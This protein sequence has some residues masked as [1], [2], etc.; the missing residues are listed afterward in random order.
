MIVVKIAIFAVTAYLALALLLYVYQR[1]IQYRPDTARVPPSAIGLTDVAEIELESSGGVRVIAWYAAPEA[2]KPVILFMHGNG[3]SISR[4]GERLA[5]YRRRGFGVMFLSY[6]GYGGSTGSPTEAGL[7]DD[8][9]AAYDWLGSQGYESRSIVLVG[10][11][12]GS[13]VAVQLA[14]RRKVAAVALE[15]PF[16]SVTDVA[17]R[18]YWYLPVGQLLKDKFDSRSL[19]AKIGAPLLIAHGDRDRVVDFEFGKRLFEA[20]SEPKEFLA[21]A[22]AGHEAIFDPRVWAREMEFF[23]LQ[24]KER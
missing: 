14:S 19:I 5:A 2:G 24:T 18:H 16:T 6:R 22:G 3:G 20:A 17:G 9:L 15:A 23:D 10:E 8:A 21:I 7:V 1:N 12:L 4:R 11:S 13:G